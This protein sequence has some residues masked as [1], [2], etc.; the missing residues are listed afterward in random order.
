MAN[1]ADEFKNR[2]REEIDSIKSTTFI[3]GEN[4]VAL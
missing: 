4:K 2:M 3:S 1:E